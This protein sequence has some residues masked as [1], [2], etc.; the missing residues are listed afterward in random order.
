MAEVY[1]LLI[2]LIRR[3]ERKP[4]SLR[5]HGPIREREKEREN[6]ATNRSPFVAALLFSNVIGWPLMIVHLPT[7]DGFHY[8]QKID[9]G[10]GDG[11][12]EA[13]R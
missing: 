6:E 10:D 7:V 2:M 3:R 5:F 12:G 1:N 11:D 8:P 9:D 4:A 13:F